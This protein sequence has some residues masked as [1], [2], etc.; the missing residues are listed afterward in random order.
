[1]MAM[2]MMMM[3]MMTMMMMTMMTMMTTVMMYYEVFSLSHDEVTCNVNYNIF[4][5][6]S[7]S[8]SQADRSHACSQA[9]RHQVT[10]LFLK[11]IPHSIIRNVGKIQ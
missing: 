1:M 3:M 4:S 8:H 2:M 7:G 9:D 11:Q 10:L 6:T 5:H